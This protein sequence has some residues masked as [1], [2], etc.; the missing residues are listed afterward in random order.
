MD[1]QHALPARA[2]SDLKKVINRACHMDAEHAMQLETEATVRG[3]LDPTSSE[4]V[5]QFTER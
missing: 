5:A 2:S 4:R 1:A 3:F